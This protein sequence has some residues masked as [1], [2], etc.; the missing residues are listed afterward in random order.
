MKRMLEIMEINKW[1]C[2]LGQGI[3]RPSKWS[4]VGIKRAK[5]I[6]KTYNSLKH[7]HKC[8]VCL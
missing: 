1:Y 2:A 8:I 3:S 5:I 4:D 6:F 7:E